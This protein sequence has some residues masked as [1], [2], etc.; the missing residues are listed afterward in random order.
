MDDL[1]EPAEDAP[2]PSVRQTA[3]RDLRDDGLPVLPGLPE[4]VESAEEVHVRRLACANLLR[5]GEVEIPIL[6][7]RGHPFEA[8]TAVPY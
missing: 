4:D 2:R 6:R 7:S 8:A 5:R 3:G 1:L